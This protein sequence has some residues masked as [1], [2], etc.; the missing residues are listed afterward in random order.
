VGC[1]L[2]L[3]RLFSFHQSKID[4]GRVGSYF[5][6]KGALMARISRDELEY[7]RNQ[8]LC[9]DCHSKDDV[10]V[11]EK[12]QK[13]GKFTVPFCRPHAN[14]YKRRSSQENARKYALTSAVKREAGECTYKGC[15]HKLIPPEL[16]PTW[17]KRESTC[18]MHGAFKAF[19]VNREALLRFII[20][21]CLTPAESQGLTPQNIIYNSGD[22]YIL[23]GLGKPGIYH[24][25][26]FS[27]SGLLERHEQF[28]KRKSPAC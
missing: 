23:L 17:W 8:K 11:A 19:R 13:R 24:T 15:R 10:T 22:G 4:F 5:S 2:I 9:F 26:G 14:A 3:G 20:Q 16:L 25:K 12:I 7:C 27:A 1:H 18:G 6:K 21:H 28:R